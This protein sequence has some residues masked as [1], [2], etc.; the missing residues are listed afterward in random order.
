MKAKGRTGILKLELVAYALVLVK[1]GS[2]KP[3]T[4]RLAM[5]APGTRNCCKLSHGA[6]ECEQL[7]ARVITPDAGV[8]GAPRRPTDPVH[9]PATS[10]KEHPPVRS[11]TQLESSQTAMRDA[12]KWLV[13]AAGAVGAVVVAGLQLKDLPHGFLATL[14]ALLGVGAALVAVAFILHRAAGVLIV[15][16]TT[17][18][19]T[20]GSIVD[21]TADPHYRAQQKKAGIWHTRLSYYE[22]MK[23]RPEKLSNKLSER[24]RQAVRRSYTGAIIGVIRA[25]R[26]LTFRS[27][28]HEDLQIDE[29]LY[30]LN[31]DAFFFTQGLAVNITELYRALRGTYVEI[32]S[33]RGEKIGRE[34][35]D[36]NAEEGVE[37]ISSPILSSLPMSETS[38]GT[39][40]ST[41]V[42]DSQGLLEKAEWRRDRLESAMGVVISFANQRLLERRFRKLIFAILFGGA[43]VAL[44]A[45]AFAV[46]PE[47]GGQQ[48]LSITQPTRVTITVVGNGLGELCPRG[49]QL[50]GVAVGGTWEEPIVVTEKAGICPA[51]QVTLNPGQAVAVPVLEPSP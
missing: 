35:E 14:V 23:L 15:G 42:S 50:Q 44:G 2:S 37:E 40:G 47:I 20:F 17:F 24:A 30:Y 43:V 49:T 36:A 1:S 34:E 39:E 26:S 29:L 48:P 5:T 10:E 8:S 4:D 9:E 33:I 19:S 21:L 18:G 46:A 22:A 7:G 25:A 16:Y 51:Q 32:L 31:Q 45:G 13:A 11:L 41:Q 12:T 38:S 28:K 3:N 27:A 6:E